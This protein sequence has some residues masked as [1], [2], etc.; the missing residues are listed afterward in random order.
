MRAKTIPHAE[1]EILMYIM[2]QIDISPIMREMGHDKHSIK[3]VESAADGV[4]ELIGN[5]M[6]RRR[7]KLPETHVD[8]KV[9]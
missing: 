1:Y 6:D 3:R 7:H 8:Y 2:Q 4:A 5:M 9:K